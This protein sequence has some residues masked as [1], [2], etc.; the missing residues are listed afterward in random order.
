MK[1]PLVVMMLGSMLVAASFG[2][3]ELE[4]YVGQY[5]VTGVPL[6]ITVTA[7]GGKLAIQATGQPKVDLELVAGENYAMKGTPIKVTFQKDA[8]GKVTGMMM[9]QAPEWMCRRRRSIRRRRL[10]VTSRRISPRLS[11]RTGSR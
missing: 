9:H 5:Q 1:K 2:Q 11:R 8:A 7:D 4:K 10:L 3:A 6:V